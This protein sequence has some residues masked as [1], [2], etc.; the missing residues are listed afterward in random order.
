MTNLK[1][2]LMAVVVLWVIGIMGL[3]I[4]VNYRRM[5]SPFGHIPDQLEGFENYIRHKER[6]LDKLRNTNIE[7]SEYR[8]EELEDVEFELRYSKILHEWLRKLSQ[9]GELK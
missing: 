7:W 4:V 1:K 8:Q 3:T 2:L 6:S 9:R 5:M